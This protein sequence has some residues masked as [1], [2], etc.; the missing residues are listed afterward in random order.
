ML[1][2]LTLFG[3]NVEELRY[4][5]PSVHENTVLVYWSKRVKGRSRGGIS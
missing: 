1:A 3:G 2:W 5:R 4:R